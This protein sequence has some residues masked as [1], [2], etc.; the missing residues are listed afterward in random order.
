MQAQQLEQ[1]KSMVF[2]AMAFLMACQ[3]GASK[4]DDKLR[5]FYQEMLKSTYAAHRAQEEAWKRFCGDIGAEPDRLL[6]AY[7]I[8]PNPL[9][10][11]AVLVVERL[12][13]VAPLD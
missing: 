11:I 8:E 3:R 5:H 4:E 10:R 9:S 1:E 6:R 2:A 13:L 12:E 7:Y